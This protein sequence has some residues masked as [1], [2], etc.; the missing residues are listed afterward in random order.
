MSVA[1][2]L[3]SDFLPAPASRPVR[4]RDADVIVLH[5]PSA[6]SVAAPVRL[7]RRGVVVLGVLV[8]LLCV[9]IVALAWRS[10]PAAGPARPAPATVT[11]RQGDTLWAIASRVA[12]QTDPRAEVARLQRLNRL[13]GPGLV[14]GQVLR[15]R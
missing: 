15:V 14:P 11:V 8:G 3:L 5:P 9:A 4:E 13:P 6:R 12:P 7:T 10:A 1:A 2:E